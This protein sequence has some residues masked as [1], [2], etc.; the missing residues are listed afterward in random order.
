MAKSPIIIII[1]SSSSTITIIITKVSRG[2][3]HFD[4]L[5]SI[6][7]GRLGSEERSS[8]PLARNLGRGDAPPLAPLEGGS[9]EQHV[10]RTIGLCGDC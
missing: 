9:N 4:D 2:V 7:S 8:I 10:E 5:R 1:S 6:A 3:R